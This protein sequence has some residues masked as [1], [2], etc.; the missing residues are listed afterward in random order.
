M[1]DVVLLLAGLVG[2]LAMLLG[3]YAL[4]AL[5][6]RHV[7]FIEDDAEAEADALASAGAGTAEDPGRFGGDDD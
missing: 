6:D 3:A 7:P 5:V 4:C 2:Y 1:T